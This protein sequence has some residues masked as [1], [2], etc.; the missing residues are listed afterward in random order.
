[1]LPFHSSIIDSLFFD[2]IADIFISSII[3]L[4]SFFLSIL[5]LPAS[6]DSAALMPAYYFFSTALVVFSFTR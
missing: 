2:I 1:L 3:S 4:M 5:I 6:F